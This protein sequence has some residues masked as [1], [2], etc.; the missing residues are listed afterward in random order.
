MLHKIFSMLGEKP[1]GPKIALILRGIPGSGKSTLLSKLPG[2]ASFSTDNKHIE[3]GQYVYKPT[4][5]HE[6]HT[7]NLAEFT[8]AAEQGISLIA[9]D[10]TNITHRSYMP[11]VEAARSNGYQVWA[12]SFV[13]GDID[14]HYKRNVHNVPMDVLQRMNYMFDPET[15]EADR[16]FIDQDP[17]KLTSEVLSALGSLM[18]TSSIK[19]ASICLGLSKLAAILSSHKSN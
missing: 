16:Q 2:V 18:K 4:K 3:N 11:Y 12:V 10:N 15:P 19:T 17:N 5:L 9:V 6:F 14:A 8:H 7:Q 1:E 13:S